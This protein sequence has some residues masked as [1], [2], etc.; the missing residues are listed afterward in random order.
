MNSYKY[1]WQLEGA[2]LAGLITSVGLI[3]RRDANPNALFPNLE[4]LLRNYDQLF[5]KVSD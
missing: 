1:S 3:S 5:D 4:L 2:S